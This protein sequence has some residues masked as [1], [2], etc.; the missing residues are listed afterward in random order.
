MVYLRG[1]SMKYRSCFYRQFNTLRRFGV[2]MEVGNEHSQIYLADAISRVSPR[3]G[4]IC[5][6]L[7][8]KNNSGWHIKT[9][10]S[11]ARCD[12]D[13]GYEI[14]SFVASGWRDMLEI[15]DAADA[16]RGAQVRVN[17]Q[18]GLH[19][20][21][22]ISDFNLSQAGSLMAAW[23]SI[24]PFMMQTVPSYRFKT[25]YCEPLRCS[26][27]FSY[28]VP[29]KPE[30]V[31]EIFKPIDLDSIRSDDR[32]RMMNV[33]NYAIGLNKKRSTRK[34]VEFRFPEGT[35]AG[36]NVANWV[37]L[38]VNFVEQYKTRSL[39]TISKTNCVNRCLNYLGL[40]HEGDRFVILSPG[41]MKTKTWL[42]RR[43]LVYG[44]HEW[45]K[46]ARRILNMMY[47]PSIAY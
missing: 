6:H 46:Q 22:D 27:R 30:E 38:F 2:E 21:V 18:C 8:S 4:K 7:Q 11:C 35:L 44:Q 26:R 9:D 32:R 37:R 31:W 5:E 23:L 47:S 1:F 13:I 17:R 10:S 28:D 42:L 15:A 39:G 34:T 43:V 12:W 40:G 41:L 25:G 24:E 20:H 36:S 45:R 16:L 3:G 33:V 14:A 29:H 19:V